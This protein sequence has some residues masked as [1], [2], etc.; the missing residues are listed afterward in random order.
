MRIRISLPDNRDYEGRLEAFDLSGAVVFGPVPAA[1]RAH[2][3]PAAAHENPSRNPLLPYGDTPLGTFVASGVVESG[4]GRGLDAE[5]FGPHGVV[6]LEP[7]AGQAAL[8]D[9]H[10]R[11]RLFIQGGGDTD[12]GL[13]A[14]AGAIRLRD[15]DQEQLVALVRRASGRVLCE[16]VATAERGARVSLSPSPPD[17]DPPALLG[18]S[19]VSTRPSA[20][21]LSDA[22]R[23][24]GARAVGFAP[25]MFVVVPERSGSGGTAYG[26]GAGIGGAGG[27]VGGDTGGVETGT[28]FGPFPDTG[29]DVAPAPGGDINP[30]PEDSGVTL[31]ESGGSQLLSTAPQMGLSDPYSPEQNGWLTGQQL[32]DPYSNIATEIGLVSFTGKDV[33]S[34]TNNPPDVDDPN[35]YTGTGKLDPYRNAIASADGGP[36][37]ADTQQ[38][39]GTYPS[40]QR[41]VADQP[42]QIPDDARWTDQQIQDLLRASEE[43][44]RARGAQAPQPT[45]N[46]PPPDLNTSPAPSPNQNYS[47]PQRDTI[48]D[49]D[50]AIQEM[51]TRFAKYDAELAAGRS[52]TGG[53]QN[54]AANAT[55]PSGDP[56]P[57]PPQ[58]IPPDGPIF[59]PTTT[60]SLSN[61]SGPAPQEPTEPLPRALSAVPG[62]AGMGSTFIPQTNWYYRALAPYDPTI[63]QILGGADILPLQLDPPLKFVPEANPADMTFRHMRSGGNVLTKGTDRISTAGT[64]DPFNS[65]SLS[66]RGTGQLARVDVNRAR[67]LGADFYDSAQIKEHL[68]SVEGRVAQQLQDAQAAGR[69]KNYINDLQNRLNAVQ[70]AQANAETFQEGEFVNRIPNRAVSEV[71][72]ASLPEAAAR[73][74]RFLQGLEILRAGGEALMVVGAIMSIE[75]IAD[76]PE[77]QTGRVVAQEAG[78]WGLSLVAAGE[79][80]ELGAVLGAAAGIET[81][82]GAIITAGLGALIFGG[83]GFF[84][85]Q[86]VADELYN[87][88]AGFFSSDRQVGDFTIPTGD[89]IAI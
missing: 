19:S 88:I 18:R 50:A 14:T 59:P 42:A 5:V 43:Y 15:L 3:E 37:P 40:V 60:P 38:G 8:A 36:I 83:I 61:G 86:E 29:V 41:D 35:S 52:G 75:R 39:Q 31:S 2:D 57:D 82:P 85:G 53:T 56:S 21:N 76:A 81:G 89:T 47:A 77:G 54:P 78:G 73:E 20:S 4:G 66:D 62:G 58:I 74:A 33:D 64:L 87:D 65:G 51:V 27:N 26:G 79:G 70:R 7:V 30:P 84:A 22:S 67:D 45:D 32:T 23:S 9:A 68:E 6:L 13:R 34:F 46:G 48:D 80:A 71:P 72:G 44:D 10:G 69:G 12:Q 16:V 11:L 25:R 49:P 24:F 63:A 17:S 28:S 1:G 55:T